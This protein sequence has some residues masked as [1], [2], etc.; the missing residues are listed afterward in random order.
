MK[1]FY[2]KRAELYGDIKTEKKHLR[3]N[4]KTYDLESKNWKKKKKEAEDLLKKIYP[5]EKIHIS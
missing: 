4:G 3:Y 2:I 1:T 5:N